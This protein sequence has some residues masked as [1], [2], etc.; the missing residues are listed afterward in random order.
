[1]G[2]SPL[3][4]LTSAVPLSRPGATCSRM[5]G[6]T[7]LSQKGQSTAQK[8]AMVKREQPTNTTAQPFSGVAL[9]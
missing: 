4:I 9:A 2:Q 6:P 7:V 8:Q 1:M 5:R 3:T